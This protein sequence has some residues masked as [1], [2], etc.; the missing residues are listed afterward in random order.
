MVLSFNYNKTFTLLFVLAESFETEIS[1]KRCWHRGSLTACKCKCIWCM[2][3]DTFCCVIRMYSEPLWSSSLSD[4]GIN[5]SVSSQRPPLLDINRLIYKLVISVIENVLSTSQWTFKVSFTV[6][7]P[8]YWIS[9]FTVEASFKSNCF[10]YSI[11]KQWGGT[12]IVI[13][14]NFDIYHGTEW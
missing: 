14:S 3:R 7:H 13:P 4:R 2:V 11:K 10:L 9:D 8:S 1:F 6:H 12:V 5:N